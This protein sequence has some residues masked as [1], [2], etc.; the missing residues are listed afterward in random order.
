MEVPIKRADLF[1]NNVP[2]S[3]FK[4]GNGCFFMKSYVVDF[5]FWL[6]PYNPH[7]KIYFF[8]TTHSHYKRYSEQQTHSVERQ[9]AVFGKLAP[10]PCDIQAQL[11]PIKKRLSMALSFAMGSRS[12][13]CWW[14]GTGKNNSDLGFSFFSTR[15]TSCCGTNKFGDELVLWDAKILQQTWAYPLSRSKS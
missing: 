12:M 9:S 15:S 7:N 3:T 4:E 1:D 14:Y 11:V 2:L 13:S 10:P 8:S 6:I 5:L